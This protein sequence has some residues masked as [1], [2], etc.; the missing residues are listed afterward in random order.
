MSASIDWGSSPAAET[1]PPNARAVAI[2]ADRSV[3]IASGRW[4]GATLDIDDVEYRDA[5]GASGYEWLHERIHGT[6]GVEV[7]GANFTMSAP[8][9]ADGRTARQL[10]EHHIVVEAVDGVFEPTQ[11]VEGA[12]ARERR[13]SVVAEYALRQH[14]R[15]GR[16]R[17]RAIGRAARETEKAALAALA[18]G[19]LGAA[20]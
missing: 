5:L 20:A 4:D 3:A 17:G 18:L 13:V 11:Y 15:A 9:F 10:S 2:N 6:Q 1:A 14:A 8:L 7:S 16:L 19:L 12:A